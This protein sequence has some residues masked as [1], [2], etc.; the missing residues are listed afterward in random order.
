[1]PYAFSHTLA[2]INHFLSLMTTVIIAA[3]EKP[4]TVS[5]MV[6]KIIQMYMSH[7]I[8]SYYNIIKHNLTVINWD[9]LSITNM[10]GYIFRPSTSNQKGNISRQH[11][12][13]QGN[14]LGMGRRSWYLA[15]LQNRYSLIA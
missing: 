10:I 3:C 12:V 5:V 13:W 1:M 8:I 2:Q 9:R 14:S 7:F 6:F 15:T 11:T 4:S